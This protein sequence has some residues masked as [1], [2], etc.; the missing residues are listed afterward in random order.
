M[1][2][3]PRHLSRSSLA[4]STAVDGLPPLPRLGNVGGRRQHD[5][6]AAWTAVDRQGG[7]DAVLAKAAARS[8]DDVPATWLAPPV[9]GSRRSGAPRRHRRYPGDPARRSPREAGQD[10]R[11][12][13]R[14]CQGAEKSTRCIE[15]CLPRATS[16]K[17][18]WPGRSRQPPPRKTSTSPKKL[19]N[20]MKRTSRPDAGSVKIRARIGKLTGDGGAKKAPA[21]PEEKPMD[22]DEE[23]PVSPPPA[24]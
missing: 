21:V 11:K 7:F 9:S 16:R 18:R 10:P 17:M 19:V 15:P 1:L 5:Y 4:A 24:P 12:V 22:D 2:R 8:A 3:C 13:R 14:P 20:S 23:K 6:T